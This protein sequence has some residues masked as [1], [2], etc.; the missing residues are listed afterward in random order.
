MKYGTRGSVYGAC[1]ISSGNLFYFIVSALG[2]GTLIATAGELFE[3]IKYAGA[4]Y[5]I[6]VGILMIK[7]SFREQQEVIVQQED[8]QHWR[9]F[10][11]AFITQISNPKAIIFFVA[12]LPQFINPA[13]NIPLQFTI[14]GLTTIVME[15]WILI[16]YGWLADKGKRLMKQKFEVRETTGQDC[17][18]GTRRDRRQ[19]HFFEKNKS[20]TAAGNLLYRRDTKEHG[21]MLKHV[22]PLQPC[23]KLSHSL[24]YFPFFKYTLPL[25]VSIW[26]LFFPPAILPVA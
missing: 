23:G 4:L 24:R 7:H 18:N 20:I 11:Q 13:G 8:V 19:S 26:I 9:L 6:I 17:G 16:F 21:E 1:G 3:Y 12:L 10:T 5:L 22:N 2:L 14:L 15:T 25:I